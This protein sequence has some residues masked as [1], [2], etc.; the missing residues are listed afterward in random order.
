MIKFLEKIFYFLEKLSEKV[1]VAGLQISDSFLQLFLIQKEESKVFILRIP[2]GVI[3]AGRVVQKEELLKLLE[4]LH[5]FIYPQR[6]DRLVS[7]VVSLPAELIYTQSFKVPYLDEEKLEESALL[8]LKMTSPLPAEKAYFS[9][10]VIEQSEENYEFLGA[11]VEKE[12]VDDFKNLLAKAKF[13]VVAFEFPALALSRAINREFSS[14]EPVLFIHLSSDGLNFFIL[15]NGFLTFDYFRS[16]RSIQG[17]ERQIT[18]TAFEAVIIE[19]TQRV[20]NFVS[21]RFHEDLKQAGLIAPGFE[22]EI[23]TLLEGR[24]GLKI[25]PLVLKE[26][27][28]SLNNLTAWGSAL[29]GQIDRFQDTFINFSGISS[30]EQYYEEQTLRIIEFWRNLSLGVLVIFLIVFITASVFLVNVSNQLEE[31]VQAFKVIPQLQ[32]IKDL[33][34]KAKEFNNSVVMV[35]NVKASDSRWLEL[36]ERWQSLAANYQVTLDNIDVRS[37]S[38]AISMAGRA[39]SAETVLNFKEALSSQQEV[40]AVDL[41]LSGISELPDRT[42]HFNLSLTL[43]PI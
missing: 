22:T 10:Q 30:I 21:S 2:P 36:L 9:W 37:R 39:P 11:V 5:N 41:P 4:Q 35:K 33:Q 15:K 29:R 16:W 40:A 19:E 20:I 26:K 1:P 18:K 34:E 7:A 24:F 31:Q 12:I 42:V 3:V 43:K 13:L 38:E 17:E 8:N 14:A 27:N 6:P 25:S 23:K 32:E 28:L